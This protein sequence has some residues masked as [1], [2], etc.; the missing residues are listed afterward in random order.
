[1]VTLQGSFIATVDTDIAKECALIQPF[2]NRVRPTVSQFASAPVGIFELRFLWMIS[3]PLRIMFLEEGA[4]FGVVDSLIDE[5]FRSFDPVSGTSLSE[6]A[7]SGIGL[8]VALPHA[9]MKPSER[10]AFPLRFS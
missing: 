3:L 5:D 2:L 4:M 8:K 6:D 7:I 10:P 1:V 9:S